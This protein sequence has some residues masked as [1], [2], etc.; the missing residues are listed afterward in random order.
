MGSAI[1]IL[2]AAFLCVGI[3]SAEDPVRR[4]NW[5]VSY[6]TAAPLGVSQQVIAI[7]GEFPGPVLELTTNWNAVVNVTNN[8]DEDFLFTWNGIQLRRNSWEDGVLGTNCPIPK[9]QNWTY[10]FQVKDQIGSFFYFPSLNL[11]RAA[12]GYG[13]II[14]H[15]RSVVPLPFPLPDGDVTLF[16]GD[17]FN[18]GHQD[19]KGELEEG[20]ELGVPDGVLI[21]G[22][23]PYRYDTTLVPPGIQ[24]ETINV[25][26]GK[27]YRFRV[28][29]VGSSTSLNLR[30]ES[31]KLLLV[32]T[33][34]SYTVQQNYTDM[35]IHVG[36]SYSFLI[37]MDQNPSSDYYIVA[38]A[39]FTNGSVWSRV[40][41]VAVLH[42]STSP[43]KPTGPLPSPPDDLYYKEYSMNQ[44]KSIRLAHASFGSGA[45][46]AEC[47]RA[48][49][50]FGGAVWNLSA[51]AARP[52]PQGSFRI[53]SINV[54]E[55]YVLK[56]ESPAAINGRL[57]A[58][59]NGVSYIPPDTPLRLADYANIS[60]VY[61]LDFPL[62]PLPRGVR[63]AAAAINSTY[64]NFVEI[65]F[66]NN[67]SVIQTYHLDG[68]SF[69]VVGM[70][71]GEWTEASRNSYNKWDAVARNTI[72]VFPGAWSAV[73]VMLDNVGI[74][75]LRAGSLDR[76]YLGQET[77]LRVV[78]PEPN[79]KTELH[80]PTNALYCGKL[81][82]RP[83]SPPL[84]R[85][86]RPR[87]PTPVNANSLPSP[88]ESIDVSLETADFTS[89]PWSSFI[90]DGTE[91][92]F[93]SQIYG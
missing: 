50:P 4:F 13:G 66:Q 78:N 70:E 56:N 92:L 32:E 63:A 74:W 80:I 26:P 65:V 16:I 10:N 51:S 40:T 25:E 93:G 76:W 6:A 11:Q 67:E 75:N 8:L 19:L 18:R 90:A 45:Y 71:Y 64:R 79:N 84:F 38:S 57:R 42:Y 30:I 48:P 89:P 44:A 34:G 41:G 87:L 68:Y 72:Q 33:E 35:D 7:N 27:T 21:N 12:G 9:G 91:E 55:T 69:F 36:Q 22:K 29:N 17:W 15:N 81:A 23:G 14:V 37:T 54:S 53:G 28:H 20:K 86:Q 60:G 83:R 1:V 61:K 24:Y 43:A 85:C 52:N 2:F 62:K 58:S 88:L 77:Y 31:H 73:L 59:I 49:R 39:R 47:C 82:R 3:C 46:S 5:E